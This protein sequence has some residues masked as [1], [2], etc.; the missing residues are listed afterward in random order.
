MKALVKKSRNPVAILLRIS[1]S[2][3]KAVLILFSISIVLWEG[4]QVIVTYKNQP[5][6]PEQKL[7]PVSNA[8]NIVMS[9]CKII[10]IGNC[11]FS[12]GKYPT[13]HECTAQQ[14]PANTY[15]NS[16]YGNFWTDVGDDVLYLHLISEILWTPFRVGMSLQTSGELCL[17]VHL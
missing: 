8:S 15:N 17:I 6:S 2:S 4:Y 3:A 7:L 14:L 10:E 5:I 12:I 13:N 11:T 9:I 16:Y 1:L